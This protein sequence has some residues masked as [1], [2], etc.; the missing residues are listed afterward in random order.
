MVKMFVAPLTTPSC[1]PTGPPEPT[2]HSPVPRA[3]A[4]GYPL[5]FLILWLTRSLFF[6][7][8]SFVIETPR[9]VAY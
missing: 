4:Y 6:T 8:N 2:H 7:R 9:R 1:I 3:S 5:G